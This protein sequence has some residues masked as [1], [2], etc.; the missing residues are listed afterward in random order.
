MNRHFFKFFFVYVSVFHVGILVFCIV[1][2]A[3]C[4]STGVLWTA[5]FIIIQPDKEKNACFFN[6]FA[7]IS[8]L[9]FETL[10]HSLSSKRHN[11]IKCNPT[12][13]KFIIYVL[14]SYIE[15]YIPNEWE[16]VRVD[17][18][19][20]LILTGAQNR[21]ICIELCSFYAI[22]FSSFSYFSGP[23]ECSVLIICQTI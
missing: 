21:K 9:I 17:G 14:T 7:L 8:L 1:F 20:E 5:S 19:T 11:E 15:K 12:L 22:F 3:A 13:P 23:F 6:E 4:H 10:Q 2:F 18:L 16:N